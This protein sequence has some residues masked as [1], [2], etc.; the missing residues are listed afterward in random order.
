MIKLR[1]VIGAAGL[2]ALGGGGVAYAVGQ[3][4]GIGGERQAFLNDVAN[5][6]HVSPGALQSAI[7]G[8]LGDRLDAA[9]KAGRLTQAQA[10]AIKQRMRQNGGA[11]F[12]GGRPHPLAGGPGGPFFA[13]PGG[14]FRAGFDAAA[15]Y[16]DLTPQQ[17]ND[18]LESGKSLADV[19]KAKN[20]DLG[21]LKTAIQNSAKARLDTAV[22]NKRITQ[23]Q[24]NRLLSGLSKRID[25]LVQL[26]GGRPAGWREHGKFRRGGPPPER[27]RFFGPPGF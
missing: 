13:G 18:Q 2:A 3:G 15:T 23:S 4:S 27:P 17:L 11:P 16:L 5:R 20:K 7:T 19:A 22:K 12:L 14:P 24:E 1:F 6:L 10:D 9:V 8:A 21:G 25:T 26:K